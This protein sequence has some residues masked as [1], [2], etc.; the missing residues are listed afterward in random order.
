MISISSPSTADGAGLVAGMHA[1][2]LPG[3]SARRRCRL[4]PRSCRSAS[5]TSSSS[6][7]SNGFYFSTSPSFTSLEK[8]FLFFSLCS[9]FGARKR[10]TVYWAQEK[11]SERAG[12][13]GHGAGRGG[14]ALAN[15]SVARLPAA[16]QS[17]DRL[18]GRRTHSIL[19]Q[20]PWILDENL[21]LFI[22]LLINY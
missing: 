13:R 9:S 18:I 19:I 15:G 3:G 11:R 20:A 5:L 4:R 8:F 21:S 1:P 6:L 17:I 14:A 7:T 22:Q 12:E 16:E 2:V 10:S